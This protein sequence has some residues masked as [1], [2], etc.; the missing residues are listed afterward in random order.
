MQCESGNSRVVQRPGLA[1]RARTWSGDGGGY[2]GSAPANSSSVHASPSSIAGASIS[3][4]LG[5]GRPANSAN[6]LALSISARV[7]RTIGIPFLPVRIAQADDPAYLS[8][9]GIDAVQRQIL[10]DTDCP[11][12]GLAIVPSCIGTLDRRTVEQKSGKLERQ[13]ALAFVPFALGAI[14][15]KI[16]RSLPQAKFRASVRDVQHACFGR[17]G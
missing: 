10:G 7:R 15:L 14:L 9:L 11:N 12:T 3:S 5:R 16:H 17:R 1:R 4:S 13:P 8:T 2:I 6:S